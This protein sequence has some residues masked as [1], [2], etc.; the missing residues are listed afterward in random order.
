MVITVLIICEEQSFCPPSP[1]QKDFDQ[2]VAQLTAKV[3]Y[4][5][6]SLKSTIQRINE[7]NTANQKTNQDN[8]AKVA[9]LKKQIASFTQGNNPE[10]E[11]SLPNSPP[12]EDTTFATPSS[13]PESSTRRNSQLPPPSQRSLT[14]PESEIQGPRP[15][16]ARTP[17]SNSSSPRAL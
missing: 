7:A 6:D 13:S 1:S 12:E 16:S 9:A 17:R 3:Q 8:M 4:L 2:T 10:P 11:D 14:Q 15:T 5:A